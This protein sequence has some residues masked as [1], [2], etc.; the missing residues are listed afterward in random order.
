M[1]PASTVVLTVPDISCAH[2]ERAIVEALRP[3]GGVG[4][5]TV[6]VP[7]RTVTVGYDRAVVGLDELK[8]VLAA[9]DY[10]VAETAP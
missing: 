8:R 5:V 2:C 4:T 10:P 9:E 6:D 1:E 3:V 7:A